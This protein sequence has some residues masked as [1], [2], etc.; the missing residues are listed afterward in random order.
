M[1]CVSTASCA[2]GRPRAVSGRASFKIMWLVWLGQLISLSYSF[3][4]LRNCIKCPVTDADKLCEVCKLG[5]Y[6][7]STDNVCLPC[8]TTVTHCSRCSAD[9]KSCYSCAD[10]RVLKTVS[11]GQSTTQECFLS[12]E[13]LCSAV[14]NCGLCTVT[15]STTT[16]DACLPGYFLQ[17]SS[18]TCVKCAENCVYCSA[19]STC[20]SCK[21]NY[22]LSS[23][24]PS[25]CTACT[26]QNC[27]LC[28]DGSICDTCSSGFH[29]NDDGTCVQ[30]TNCDDVGCKECNGGHAPCTKCYKGYYLTGQ[31]CTLC[32]VD[33][34]NCILC[35]SPSAGASSRATLSCTRCQQGYH[36]RDNACESCSDITNH[37]QSCPSGICTSCEPGYQLMNYPR[38]C[39]EKTTTDCSNLSNCLACTSASRCI[40][41]APGYSPTNGVCELY[42]GCAVAN[43]GICRSDQY[44]CDFCVRGYRLEN[45]QCISKCTDRNCHTCSPGADGQEVCK[46]CMPGYILDTDSGVCTSCG[47]EKCVSCSVSTEAKKAS[48]SHA[49]RSFSRWLQ[50]LQSKRAATAPSNRIEDWEHKLKAIAQYYRLTDIQLNNLRVVLYDYFTNGSISMH[51]F[52]DSDLIL[53]EI[54][55]VYTSGKQGVTEA[56]LSSAKLFVCSKC[57]DGYTLTHNTCVKQTLTASNIVGISAGVILAVGII[58]GAIV[59]T[60]TSKKH[61]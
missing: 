45:N 7:D 20:T 16:C 55:K 53:K 51:L 39:K 46:Q 3:C 18:N 50:Q 11:T 17:S 24:L 37:C 25:T 5:Y 58:A 8:S 33:I 26:L 34:S 49:Y 13:Q 30:N 44:T 47:V 61:K 41:C 36:L 59:M 56:S 19:E 9:G 1:C 57:E 22:T 29:H 31:T 21:D 6:L 48:T 40:S 43:C 52:N 12:Q 14:S 27:D 4:P 15:D 38:Y 32:S 2:A 23:P 35:D 28:Y 42:T 60:V 54:S 10:G